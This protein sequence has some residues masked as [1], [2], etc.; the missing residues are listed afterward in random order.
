MSVYAISDLH[1]RYD[2]FE[3]IKNHIKPEDKVYVLGDCGDRGPD[4]WKIIKEVY[5]NPQFIYIKGNH[6]DMLVKAMKSFIKC[7]EDERETFLAYNWDYILCRQ[8]GGEKTF[9]NWQHEKWNRNSWI[10]K[11]DD[12]PLEEIYVNKKG[13]RIVMCHAG[14]TPHLGEMLWDEDYLWN[15]EHFSSMWDMDFVDTFIIHGH[16]PIPYMDEYIWKMHCDV[17]LDGSVGPGVYWYSMDDKGINH[18]CNIDCG[19][20]FT[21]HTA[22]LNLDT[23]EQHVFMAED[24]VYED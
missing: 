13:Q 15:R 24:C 17:D 5:E 7:S 2:L 22:L 10:K 19:A 1:G 9:K 6:E 12:L 21:G 16:T 8:N 14:Y 3:M 11:L 20:F 23:F 4:G 18:K